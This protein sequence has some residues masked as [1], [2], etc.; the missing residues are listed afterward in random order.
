MR[1]SRNRSRIAF[2]TGVV[3]LAIAVLAPPAS[4]TATAGPDAAPTNRSSKAPGPSPHTTTTTRSSERVEVEVPGID[5]DANGI[6]DRITVDIIRPGEA[7]QAGIDVP[8][9][10]QASPYYA[11]DSKTY[12]DA[13][14]TRQVFGS[15][16]DNYF[17]PRGYAV[18][19]VDMPGTFRSTSCSDVGARSRGAR[20]QGRDRLVRTTGS[21]RTPRP[22][23]RSRPT[24]P[25][26]RPA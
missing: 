5:A 7:A 26:G 25:P 4:L 20:H 2:R 22:A 11:G 3:L 16:L 12:F 14:G 18:A 13:N 19:F 17:V 15:W 10:I 23:R 6:K 21:P 8:V 9:I 1:K 24:G